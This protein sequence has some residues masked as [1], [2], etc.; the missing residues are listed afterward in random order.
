MASDTYKFNN[1]ILNYLNEQ[2]K[3][4]KFCDV[5]IKLEN[6]FA[7]YAH[8]CIIAPQSTFIGGEHFLQDSWNF[9]IQNPLTIEIKNFEC[10]ECLEVMFDFFYS[11]DI[12]ISL[13]HQMHM[14]VLGNKLGAV[15]ILQIL[16]DSNDEIEE[17]VNREDK[18]DETILR[19][20]LKPKKKN[21]KLLYA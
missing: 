13:E 10:S 21:V 14:K 12:S 5:I 15:D 4:G 9:S 11:N 8:F 17:T 20:I 2:R 16:K 18:V 19:K 3:N 1:K 7:I 6:T